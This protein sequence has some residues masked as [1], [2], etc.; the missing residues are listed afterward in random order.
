MLVAFRVENFPYPHTCVVS[1]LAHSHLVN[2]AERLP[3]PAFG[4]RDRF[5]SIRYFARLDGG[6]FPIR[7]ADFPALRAWIGLLSLIWLP[8][9]DL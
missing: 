1:G 2:S 7:G 5:A 6:E 9:I 4:M 3:V 8:I